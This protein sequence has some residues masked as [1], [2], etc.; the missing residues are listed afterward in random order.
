MEHTQVAVNSLLLDVDKKKGNFLS[1]TSAPFPVSSEVF[2]WGSC[3]DTWDPIQ[4]CEQGLL[5]VSN[6]LKRNKQARSE[7]A[8]YRTHALFRAETVDFFCWVCA[9]VGHLA[10]G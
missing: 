3:I 8:L 10:H 9:C 1:G 5:E 6:M 7:T 4:A 2:N